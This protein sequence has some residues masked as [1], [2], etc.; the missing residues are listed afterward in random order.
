LNALVLQVV[1]VELPREDYL[2]EALILKG[3]EE[4][5]NLEVLH[6]GLSVGW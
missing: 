3:S 4:H 6:S 1:V 5:P 2:N